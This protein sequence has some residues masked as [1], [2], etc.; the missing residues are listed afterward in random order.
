MRKDIVVGQTILSSKRWPFSRKGAINQ[1]FF[2]LPGFSTA[3]SVM[4]TGRELQFYFDFAQ[5]KNLDFEALCLEIKGR[6]ITAERTRALLSEW[7]SLSLKSVI[8]KGGCSS[9]QNYLEK[10]VSKL[11][12]IQ[13][14]L[15]TE[16][17]SKEILKLLN[18]IK[19]I[20]ACQL[21][22]Y[23]PANILQGLISDIHASLATTST[24]NGADAFFVDRS[25]K[26]ETTKDKTKS[27]KIEYALCAN[28][29]DAGRRTM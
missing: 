23:K 25:T 12:D 22:Y 26:Q 27:S 9:D 15:P 14:A 6:F 10:L 11:Q 4:F 13:S 28:A 8:A 5:R 29:E 17:K 1:G 20:D 7:N 24:T 3:F 21:A 2:T 18:S 16:Y 19:D